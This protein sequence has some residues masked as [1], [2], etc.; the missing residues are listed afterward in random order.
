VVPVV[1]KSRRYNMSVIKKSVL[2]DNIK[3]S[4][5]HIR[6][7]ALDFL[8]ALGEEYINE[9]VSEAIRLLKFDGKQ[10]LTSRH[11]QLATDQV[12]M[13]LSERLKQR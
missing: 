2:N 6:K 11:I 4:G 9:L 7:E 8:V 13:R 1:F 5:Y 10:I 12:I 3:E